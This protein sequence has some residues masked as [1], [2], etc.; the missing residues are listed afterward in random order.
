M[1]LNLRGTVEELVFNFQQQTWH[2]SAGKALFWE[3]EK[4]LILSDLHLGKSAHFRKA[5]IAVPAGIV[6][7]DL[8]R[9]QQLITHYH[10]VQLIV[11]GD[12]FHSS[13]NNDV[14]YFRLWRQQFPQIHFVLVKGNHDILDASLYETLQITVHETLTLRNIHFMHEPCTTNGDGPYVFSGHLHPG[15]TLAGSGKQSL[16]LPC[17]Y[18]GKTCGILPAFG[19]FT[20]LAM[21]AP[22]TDE[23]VFAIANKS[24]FR[25][26][27]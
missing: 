13:A 16:R 17:F 4:A 7:E 1:L 20:G 18:F 19:R 8:F 25:I 9:L 23:V 3:E 10:P 6:Q 27:G 11:V 26:N 21:L 14:Q 15:V 5:G 2:L 22:D 24:I 12:L